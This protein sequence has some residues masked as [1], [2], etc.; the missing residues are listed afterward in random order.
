MSTEETGHLAIGFP[1]I[2]DTRARILI[3]GSMPGVRSLETR[4]YYAHARNAF[5]PIMGVL[6]GAGPELPYAERTA[7]LRA[8]G[9]AVWDVFSRCHRPGS[10]DSAIDD[11]TAVVN[12]FAGFFRRH[13]RIRRVCFNGGKA[14]SVYRRD[15]LPQVSLSA[16]Y[17]SHAR[18]PSTSPAY[19]AMR[20]EAKL[21]AWRNQLCSTADVE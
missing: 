18:L 15:V 7:A 14:A 2:A 16:P 9:I 5:W 17:L 4:Q 20:F 3:L 13:R 12:D 11:R 1:P 21:E 19:A 10:L 8:S 6:F